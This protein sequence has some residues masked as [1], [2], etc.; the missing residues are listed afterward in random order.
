MRFPMYAIELFYCVFFCIAILLS[1]YSCG[2]LQFHRALKIVKR[3]TPQDHLLT[4]KINVG[5]LV[6]FLR[7]SNIE[8]IKLTSDVPILHRNNSL[9]IIIKMNHDELTTRKILL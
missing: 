2:F 8:S 4:L 9:T 1:Y 7:V 3:K 5:Q 6:I